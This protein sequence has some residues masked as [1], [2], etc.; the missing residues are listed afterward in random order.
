M[1]FRER[2]K[3][4]PMMFNGRLVVACAV[5]A[6]GPSGGVSRENISDV[7]MEFER[8]LDGTEY[9]LHGPGAGVRVSKAEWIEFRKSDAA[10][11]IYQMTDWHNSRTQS[12]FLEEMRERKHYMGGYI[13]KETWVMQPPDVKGFGE[14]KSDVADSKVCECVNVVYYLLTC[15]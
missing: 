12:S 3:A 15:M 7:M 10:L 14:N 5:V 1:E 9:N 13:P 6:G 2:L 4:A 11:P 8:Y